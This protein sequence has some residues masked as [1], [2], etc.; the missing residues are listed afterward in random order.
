MAPTRRLISPG[1]IAFLAVLASGF[2]HLAMQFAPRPWSALGH[3]DIAQLLAATPIFQSHWPYWNFPFE[4]HPVIGWGSALLSY[5]PAELITIISAWLV[6]M[7]LCARSTASLLAE[8]VGSRNAVVFWSLSPQLLLF[9]GKNFD[10]LAVLT[11]LFATTALS[12]G[13]E[14]RAGVSIAIGTATKLF[15]AIA[16]PPYVLSLWRSGARRRMLA[17]LVG[18]GVALAILDVPAIVAPYSLLA[19]GVSPYG[20]ASWNIDSIWFAAAVT[21]GPFLSLGALDTLVTGVSIIGLA[22]SYFVWVLLPAYRGKDPEQAAWLGVALLV[23]WTRLRSVQYAMW[24]LP[25]FAL[26]VRDARL[27]WAM[28]VGDAAAFAG[29]FLLRGAPSEAPAPDAYTLYGLILFG[30]VVRQLAM[31]RLIRAV[32]A[33]SNGTAAT[34]RAA[35]PSSA[36]THSPS[37][38]R[39]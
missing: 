8:R 18:A 4:Y 26:Y 21:L 16:L 39:P 30:V 28:F 37:M 32:I 34:G 7:A 13:R 6:V 15:P 23:F 14:V 38:T 33:R 20:V 17:L 29:V 19:Y 10:A 22:L 35:S 5:G 31:V 1:N 25:L 9:S 12:Q 36:P 2:A 24:L 11:L 27:M 3:I